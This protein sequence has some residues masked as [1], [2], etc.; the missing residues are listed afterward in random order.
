M[1]LLV[2]ALIIIAAFTLMMIIIGK[3]VADSENKDR[4]QKES[5]LDFLNDKL[6]EEGFS[7][8]ERQKRLNYAKNNYST[9][10]DGT[11]SNT[12]LLL[13]LAQTFNEDS[14]DTQQYEDSI[15]HDHDSSN[16]SSSSFD[17]SSSDSG[18]FSD[19]G[20]SGGDSGGGGGD[21]SF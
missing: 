9:N 18:G 3:G 6:K 5:E 11:I 14:S 10:S 12:L 4:K 7:E 8:S 2:A 13:M 20:S 15:S 1:K 16:D 21:S 17:S 19:S